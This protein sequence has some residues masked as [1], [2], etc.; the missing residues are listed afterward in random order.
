MATL[1][2]LRLQQLLR[3]FEGPGGIASLNPLAFQFQ[4]QLYP[5]SNNTMAKNIM[6]NF[7]TQLYPQSEEMRDAQ[8]L[9][10]R[11]DGVFTNSVQDP[12]F[13]IQNLA[14]YDYDPYLATK[15]NFNFNYNL[16]TRPAFLRTNTP[17]DMN[18]F[19]GVSD[20]SMIDETTND[21]Q[22][23]NYIEQVE[24]SRNP[25]SGIMDLLRNIPTPFN[26]VRRGLEA[27]RG[28]E[29]LSDFRNSRT[30]A[31]FFKRRRDREALARDPNVFRDARNITSNL[32]RTAADD[33]IDRGRGQS[34]NAPTR[35]APTRSAAA[36]RSRDLGSMRGGV[37]R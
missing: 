34:S 27:L 23:Q 18:R 33:V 30:G 24:K 14:G 15:D 32:R 3:P 4:N 35:S 36:T 12:A 8:I 20:M 2:E 16:G 28:S 31:E 19:Q 25:L 1:D 29:S 21:E 26:L 7:E 9:M 22:D 13:S 11:P 6:S 37:G 5:Q 10:N 17:L